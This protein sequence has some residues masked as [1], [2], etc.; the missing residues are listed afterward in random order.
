MK[1]LFGALMVKF[2]ILYLSIMLFA[3]TLLILSNMYVLG[4]SMADLLRYNIGSVLLEGFFGTVILEIITM[5]GLR[6][7]CGLSGGDACPGKNYCAS[8]KEM[9]LFPSRIFRGM[10]IFGAAA[11]VF[12]HAEDVIARFRPSNS[13]D[14][15]QLAVTILFEQNLSLILAILFFT[16]ARRLLRPYILKIPGSEIGDFRSA[17]FT[18]NLLIIFF[19]LLL[20]NVLTPLSYILA[21][22]IDSAVPSMTTLLSIFLFDLCFALAVC[23]LTVKELKHDFSALLKAM[24]SLRKE[25]AVRLEAK[26]P[27]ITNDEAGSLGFIFNKLQDKVS[28][29]FD[30]IDA[31]LKMA[32]SVQQKLLPEGEAV[33][34]HYRAAGM[35]RPCREVGGDF[36]DI[37][38][39]DDK[40][41]ALIIG[42]VTGNGMPAALLMSAALLLFRNEIRKGYAPGESLSHLNKI[43]LGLGIGD[44]C[45]T[46][47]IALFDTGRDVLR[48]AGAGHVN[49]YVLNKSGARQIFCSSLPLGVSNGETYGE[50]EYAMEADD[51]FIFYTD[52]LIEAINSV[53]VSG[54]EV[55][56]RI[57]CSK[58]ISL[59]ISRYIASIMED[60]DRVA[61]SGREDDR[62]I[63][64]VRSDKIIQRAD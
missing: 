28:K 22:G 12:Y 10:V 60:T 56:E 53:S 46:A 41:F 16:G 51:M 21:C 31:E 23:L 37:V 30:E 13:A 64:A 7:T 8:W 43:I 20:I 54:F 11:S 44:F 61:E 19:S 17:T 34:G 9:V 3:V 63:V 14:Y 25:P 55:F 5:A 36:F 26:V 48:Y 29:E 49:P 6:N 35:C 52:G 50:T 40:R 2:L 58:D 59:P 42:D 57:L 47:G 18:K 33:C 27:V 1:R 4:W 24:D 38:I 15:M 62:T 39:L 32:R 45:L